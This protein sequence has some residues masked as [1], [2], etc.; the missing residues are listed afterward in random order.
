MV[1]EAES[2]KEALEKI[3]K[4]ASQKL[5]FDLMLLDKNLPTVDINDLGASELVKVLQM[6]KGLLKK[7]PLLGDQIKKSQHEDESSLQKETESMLEE[8][9]PSAF[10][11]MTNIG[12]LFEGKDSSE[13]S[14]PEG[15]IPDSTCSDDGSD[16]KSTRN[17]QRANDNLPIVMMTLSTNEVISRYVVFFVGR[18]PFIFVDFF[19][20]SSIAGKI[21]SITGLK[22][23]LKGHNFLRQ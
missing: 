7:I 2:G 8:E 13:S 11:D 14:I 5:P 15:K 12:K 17:L 18:K 16:G 23:P 22:N 9:L 3:Q 21:K 1:E 6:K 20:D 10:K 19:F 4:A